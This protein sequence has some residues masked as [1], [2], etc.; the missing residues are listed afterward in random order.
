[1]DDRNRVEH[2]A[3]P[4]R[5]PLLAALGAGFGLAFH[6]LIDGDG[7]PAWTDSPL[8]TGA[9]VFLPVAGAVFALSLERLRWT[10]SAAFAAASGLLA[11]FVAGWNGN[12]DNWGSGEGWQFF[13]ALLAAGLAL[14]LFQSFRDR[15]L[16]PQTG[17]VHAHVW[18]DLILGGAAAAFVVATLLLTLL[19]GELFHLIG[20]DLLRDLLG[21][22]GFNLPLAG[23]AFGA[24]V[25]LL[26]DRDQVLGTLQKVARAVLSVL[27]P[28]LALGLAVFVLALPVTGLRPL[29][30]QT[31][32][33]TPI[34]LACILGAA[35]LANAVIGN[36]SEEEARSPALRYPAV[37]LALV[38][39]PL[40][41]VAA[42]STGKRI[43]QYGLTPDRIWACVFVLAAAA[44]ASAYLYALARRRSGWPEALRRANVQVASGLCLLALFLALPILD[45]G[46]IS[47]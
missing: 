42:V 31:Q 1:M 21:R 45:F 32:A 11:A 37:A 16:R 26:R 15:G 44:F 36:D 35:L 22:G 29:W 27:A 13:A 12:P 9:A 20:I 10:W 17:I 39:S 46:A 8:R 34:L 4:L 7:G 2:P 30:D 23:A 33:T 43:G 18:T 38:M 28:F 25:G 40:A 5:A 14:P 19:L 3:W 24:A 6:A 47:T 41:L